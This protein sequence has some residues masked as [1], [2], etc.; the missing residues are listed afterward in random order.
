MN[1][2][3]ASDLLEGPNDPDAHPLI[4]KRGPTPDKKVET[5][6]GNET[7]KA[8]FWSYDEGIYFS[9]TTREL[10]IG[11]CRVVVQTV[12][13]VFI[14][15]VYFLSW[16]VCDICILLATIGSCAGSCVRIDWLAPS[17]WAGF[18]A[19][20]LRGYRIGSEIAHIDVQW[21]L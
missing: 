5:T 4:E 21:K 19:S 18:L 7:K 6:K 9:Y 16:G 20:L 17:C 13:I 1:L 15:L 2:W 3:K 8:Y 14:F 10:K 12:V 11:F